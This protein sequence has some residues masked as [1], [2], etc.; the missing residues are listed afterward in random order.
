M[1]QGMNN[2]LHQSLLFSWS[3]HYDSGMLRRPAEVLGQV[4]VATRMRPGDA[5]W[6]L[7]Y[8]GPL[9]LLPV[10]ISNI[11][12]ETLEP[13]QGNFPLSS[14]TTSLAAPIFRI[15]SIA[16]Q[17]PRNNEELSRGR[18]PEV[19]SKIL[20]YL[21]QTLSSLDVGKHD[22]VRDEEL[23][24][25]VVSVCQSQKINHTLKVQLFATLVLD[26]KIW[27]LCS[28]GIQKKLLSSLADMVFTESTVMRDANA[29]QMLLD[30][31]RRCYWIVREIDS[32]NSFSLA[33]A[34]R[35]VGEINALVDELLVVVE[36]LIVAAPPSLVSADVRCLL[37]FMVDCP[38]PN[39]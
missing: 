29:I 33:G 18:G 19:L 12:E 15:I 2:F 5:L 37:G 10:T 8:G 17:H 30:G 14:A 21:L 16:I 13:L 32:V 36:L 9:S 24:A 38:Q 3:L 23:V 31:C 11:D 39:Q 7:A 34:T 35:P 6:A 26:L 27:S 22:G 28:Y 20:N 4:H 25:A 1:H